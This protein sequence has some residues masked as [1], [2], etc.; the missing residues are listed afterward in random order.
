MINHLYLLIIKGNVRLDNLEIKLV[1]MMYRVHLK[2][3][4]D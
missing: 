3:S 1:C 2:K 4:I